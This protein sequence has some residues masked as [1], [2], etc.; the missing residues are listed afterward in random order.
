MEYWAW[1][2]VKQRAS[3]ADQEIVNTIVLLAKLYKLL[4]Q[5]DG[6]SRFMYAQS[7]PEVMRQE[8]KLF[9]PATGIGP[10]T[11]LRHLFAELYTDSVTLSHVSALWLELNRARETL[12]AVL[13]QKQATLVKSPTH[14]TEEG[15]DAEDVLL[16]PLLVYP[17]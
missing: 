7:L 3:V 17:A 11:F 8:A 15:L 16:P 14:S 1:P 5:P 6:T 9:N 4:G 12:Y 13:L 10:H 2:I